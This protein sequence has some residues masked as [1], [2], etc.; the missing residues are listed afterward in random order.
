MRRSRSARTTTGAR[1]STRRSRVQEE[2]APRLSHQ[3][4]QHLGKARVTRRE[5]LDARDEECVDAQVT[6]RS[7]K[8]KEEPEKRDQDVRPVPLIRAPAVRE[9]QIDTHDAAQKAPE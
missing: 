3:P 8:E 1:P 5:M 2:L 6:A 4:E 7:G 9:I